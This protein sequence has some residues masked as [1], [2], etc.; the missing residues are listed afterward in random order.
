MKHHF[1][2]ALDRSAGHWNLVPN[3]QRYAHHIDKLPK[4]ASGVRI[5]TI[6]KDDQTWR[7][8]ADLPALEEV[9]LHEPSQ[10]QLSFVSDLGQITR[11]R[12]TH[13]RPKSIEFL[14]PLKKLEELVLEYVSGFSDL[15][16]VSSLPNIRALHL[17][18]L[19]RVS[20]FGGLSG[21]KN[22]RHLTIDGTL[23]WKQPITGF[24]FASGL[25]SLEVLRLLKVITKA[26]YPATLPL[27]SLRKLKVLQAHHRVFAR[28]EYALLE[29]GLSEVQGADW[30]PYVRFAYSMMSLPPGD[31]RRLLSDE[32]LAANHPEVRNYR[33]LGRVI[34]DPKDEWFEFTGK[35]E[36]RIKCTSAKAEA[37]CRA[38]EENYLELRSEARGLIQQARK[39]DL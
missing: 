8:A 26:Q 9:T 38:S 32:E 36:G 21:A 37:K 2:D 7:R 29:E 15:G 16:P 25:P 10:E 14:A 17:E 23:D 33:A 19:R 30:G 35:G 11:L 12:I 1:G 6:G 22:L 28:R 20:D 34:P 24:G 31:P 39:Q 5:V 3:A 18:N 27:V 13:A 4:D